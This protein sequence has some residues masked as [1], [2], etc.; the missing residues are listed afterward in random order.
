MKNLDYQVKSSQ[1]KSSQ[2][3]SSQVKS[4]NNTNMLYNF[5]NPICKQLRNQY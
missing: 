5:V 2:V 3:K 1:V 4:S